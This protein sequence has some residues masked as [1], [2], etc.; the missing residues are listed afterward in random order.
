VYPEEWGVSPR[1]HLEILPKKKQTPRRYRRQRGECLHLWHHKQ[2]ARPQA[3]ARETE[4]TANLLNKA[5]K[6]ADGKDVVGA[7]FHKEKSPCN[8]SE[9]SDEKE[10]WE[11]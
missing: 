5:T 7:I 9:P 1:L 6:F 11:H 2:G 3:R 4:A 10:H 8:A